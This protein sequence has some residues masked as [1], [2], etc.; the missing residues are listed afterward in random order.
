MK[1][2]NLESRNQIN[3]FKAFMIGG[4]LMILNVGTLTKKID[5]RKKKQSEMNT[6]NS[7]FNQRRMQTLAYLGAD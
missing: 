3:I 7:R 5:E 1:Q 2:R 4:V 6:R